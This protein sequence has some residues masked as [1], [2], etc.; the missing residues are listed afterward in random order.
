[1]MITIRAARVKSMPTANM[2]GK[3]LFLEKPSEDVPPT[4]SFPFTN[5]VSVSALVTA[6][7]RSGEDGRTLGVIASVTSG[8]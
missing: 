1:M 6:S 2:I 3:I 4:V 8:V 7:K 5:G